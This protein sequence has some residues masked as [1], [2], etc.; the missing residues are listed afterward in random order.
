MYYDLQLILLLG[1]VTDGSLDGTAAG[2]A[3]AVDDDDDEDDDDD[4]DDDDAYQSC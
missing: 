2:A 3:S 4:Y 1:T